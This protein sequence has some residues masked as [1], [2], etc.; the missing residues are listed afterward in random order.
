MGGRR[1]DTAP[2]V[3]AIC[4]ASLSNNS[5][6]ITVDLALRSLAADLGFADTLDL[7]TVEHE[8]TVHPLLQYRELSS[9]QQL[10]GYDRIVYWGDFLHSRPYHVGDLVNRAQTRGV[11]AEEMLG[12]RVLPLLLADGASPDLARRIIVSGGSLYINRIEDDAYPQ[13]RSAMEN[14][15]SGARLALLRD[16]VS[17]QYASRFMRAVTPPDTLGVDSAFLLRPFADLDWREDPLPGLQSPILGFSFGRGLA[18]NPESRAAMQGFVKEIAARLGCTE[19][20]DVAWLGRNRKDP[21]GGV[22]GKLR[23][24]RTL[25]AV[26]TDTY[27]CA[28]NS[29]REGVPAI[30]IGRGAEHPVGPL[31]DKKKELLYLMFNMKQFYCFIEQLQ[32]DMPGAVERAAAALGNEAAIDRVRG[33]IEL[34]TDRVRARLVDALL[35]PQINRQ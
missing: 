25:R 30:C 31:S 29:W 24:I 14:L 7:Y 2:R 5:G 3:A 22:M 13:Y 11:T 21:V 33:N 9:V 16:P 6:M 27:H 35:G 20:C 18:K 4:A 12:S 26:V 28:V 17:A 8:H 15:Y 19:L 1:K 32:T 23:T 10:E 34:S